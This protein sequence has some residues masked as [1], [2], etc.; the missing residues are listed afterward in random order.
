[1]RTTSRKGTSH[2]LIVTNRIDL[3]LNVP[4]NVIHLKDEEKIFFDTL[5]FATV[6][7]LI[8]LCA[9]PFSKQFNSLNMRRFKQIMFLLKPNAC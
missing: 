3:T 4:E 1:M 7:Y 8:F 9:F 5:L 6:F 2:Q